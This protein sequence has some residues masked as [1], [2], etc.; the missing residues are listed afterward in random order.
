MAYSVGKFLFTHAG[1]SSDW[2]DDTIEDWHI[3]TIADD[4]NELFKYKP[5]AVG[6]RPYRTVADQ[7]RLSSGYGDEIYQGPLW[8]R[9]RSLM[10]ANYDT[11]RREIIQV[12][13]HT[14]QTQIDIK[15]GSTGGR[16]YFIDTLERGCREYL[17]IENNTVKLGKLDNKKTN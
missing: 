12:V 14:P 16:Y 4:V 9:P 6:Y 3:D 7:T 15:G 11:L 5:H 8:I 17:I 13:G 1:V 2:L 10:K